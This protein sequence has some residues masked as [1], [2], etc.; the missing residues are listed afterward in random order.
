MSWGL[1]LNTSC[2]AGLGHKIGWSRRPS[3]NGIKRLNELSSKGLVDTTLLDVN[4]ILLLMPLYVLKLYTHVYYYPS[5]ESIRQAVS[6]FIMQMKLMLNVLFD[7]ICINDIFIE[8]TS[9]CS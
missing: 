6:E 9:L 8:G 2:T 1:E 5:I 7:V 4:G 3:T